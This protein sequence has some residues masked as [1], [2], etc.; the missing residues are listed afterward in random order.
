MTTARPQVVIL[1]VGNLLMTDEGLGVHAINLLEAG[2]DF[3]PH[4]RLIDGGTSTQDLRGELEDLDHLIIIDAVNAGKPPAS[5]MRFEDAE[6]PAVFTIKFSPHQVGIS[7]L[8]ATL[9]FVSHEPKH[10][11]LFGVEP[12]V[13]KLGMDVSPSV[14][15]VLPEVVAQVIAELTK[16]GCAPTQKRGGGGAAH[17]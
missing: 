10:V 11:V 3:P 4:V 2:Y 14:A 15:K 16:L 12:D 5:V 1:G 6:V 13:L 9:K 7:D 8:L 17:A